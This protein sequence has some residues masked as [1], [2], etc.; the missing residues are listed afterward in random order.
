MTAIVSDDS[1]SVVMASVKASQSVLIRDHSRPND[2]LNL[3]FS[4]NSK[5]RCLIY[6]FF[7]CVRS[8]RLNI[9]NFSTCSLTTVTQT[10]G[11]ELGP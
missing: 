1:L 7:T 8:V 4:D 2:S 11:P 5:L 9:I 10:C 3:L 6:L